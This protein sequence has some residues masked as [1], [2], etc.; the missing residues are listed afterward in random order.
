MKIKLLIL[1]CPAH[2]GRR[3]ISAD[4]M[5]HQV[6]PSLGDFITWQAWSRPTDCTGLYV[7]QQSLR[8][9]CSYVGLYWVI[10]PRSQECARNP[11]PVQKASTSGAV[12]HIPTAHVSSTRTKKKVSSQ[13]HRLLMDPRSGRTGV[14]GGR[15]T[16]E[17]ERRRASRRSASNTQRC[18]GTAAAEEPPAARINDV[19]T[20]DL[21]SAVSNFFLF[22]HCTE[23]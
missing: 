11:W 5:D 3:E 10:Q 17:Q 7:T 12:H 20:L 18:R 23:R 22:N 15:E 14:V 8:C 9:F 2:P 6:L 13:R 19:V 1:N 16:A 21:G 4:V